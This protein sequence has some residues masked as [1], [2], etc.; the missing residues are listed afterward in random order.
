MAVKAALITLPDKLFHG[1][2]WVV[3]ILALFIL[4]HIAWQMVV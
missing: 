4:S 1:L 2:L 3:V